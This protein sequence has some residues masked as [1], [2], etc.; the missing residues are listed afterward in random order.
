MASQTCSFCNHANPAGAK[1]CNECGSGLGLRPCARCDA[2]NDV[3][4]TFCHHC[5]A[6]LNERAATPVGNAPQS[7][8]EV[9]AVSE[10]SV[11]RALDAVA[12]EAANARAAS[13]PSVKELSSAAER[14]NAFWRD[15][16]Q[17]VEVERARKPDPV[18]SPGAGALETLPSRV[19]S[20][21]PVI[22]VPS[23]YRRESGA[24]RA[25]I[26]LVVL[27]VVGGAAY[28]GYEQSSPTR[29][30]PAASAPIAVP[31]SAQSAPAQSP[32]SS[33][34]TQP[35]ST[36]SEAVATAPAATSAP[37]SEAA[38]SSS[39]P[40]NTEAAQ[41]AT[42]AA[43]TATESASAG[44]ASAAPA[45]P[46]PDVQA[47][48]PAP[49]EPVATKAPA[50]KVPPV[51]AKPPATVV[52]RRP[53]NPNRAATSGDAM[54]NA[55]SARVPAG[56]NAQPL[57]LPPTLSPAVPAPATPPVARGPCTDSVAA[58]GLCSR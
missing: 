54:R 4:A 32:Q 11:V 12:P 15:S 56:G 33:P 46:Q 16:M 37:S 14:L 10:S 23:R 6:L 13:A 7:A 39:A 19:E 53:K 58:L 5:G 34:A 49:P 50:A 43:P 20:E 1:F 9:E 26:A 48:I 36:A 18:D 22:D 35:A 52:L 47:A 25:A 51:V 31:P 27:A 42:F 40:P 45:T 21:S 41:P 2:I 8:R 24:R 30:A 28:Y 29:V 57:S 55:G 17:A 3:G 38:T 44:A